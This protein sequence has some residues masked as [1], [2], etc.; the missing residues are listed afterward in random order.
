MY[1]VREHLYIAVFM[2]FPVPKVFSEN[3]SVP[4]REAVPH[5]RPLFSL[6]CSGNTGDI[7]SCQGN[8]RHVLECKKDVGVSR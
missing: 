2:Y 8:I 7:C 5:T 6:P 4:W 1:K 3:P